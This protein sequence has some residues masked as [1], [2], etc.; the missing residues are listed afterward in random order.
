[1]NSIGG[2]MSFQLAAEEV[3]RKLGMTWGMAQKTVLE[4]CERNA[5]RWENVPMGGPRVSH[6]DLMNCL[7]ERAVQKVGG[8]QARIIALLQKRFPEGRVPDRA[9]VPRERLRADLL[10]MDKTLEPLNL[11]TLKRAIDC[12]NGSTPK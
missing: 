12:Y 3:E 9:Q 8:K 7:K 2:W 11:T 10:E 5:V 1:M 6:N 4:W